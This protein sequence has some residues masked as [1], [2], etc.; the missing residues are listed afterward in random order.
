MLSPVSHSP[1]A[2]IFCFWSGWYGFV[3]AR[4]DPRSQSPGGDF[5][6]LVTYTGS[7]ETAMTVGHSPLA[8]VFCFWSY[9][10][11]CRRMGCWW[12]S[13]SPGGDFLF[14]VN[15]DCVGATYTGSSSQSPG[16]DF[17]FLVLTSYLC[18]VSGASGHS[19]LAGIFCFWSWRPRRTGPYSR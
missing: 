10:A 12:Q 16:G 13:Q 1:L 17:L 14:L 15:L 3:I 6:F 2:G 11:Q 5:L 19:P 9:C 4:I 7:S 8:G 18:R